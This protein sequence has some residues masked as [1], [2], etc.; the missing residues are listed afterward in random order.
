MGRRAG[1]ADGPRLESAKSDERRAR[2][3]KTVGWYY[4]AGTVAHGSALREDG[5]AVNAYYWSISGSQLDQDTC[6]L[7]Y[8]DDR[9]V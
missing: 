3:Q 1:P 2:W 7:R 4:N 9:C 5:V 6:L 8:S